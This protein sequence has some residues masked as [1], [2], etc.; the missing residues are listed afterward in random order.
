M[1]YRLPDD[2]TIDGYSAQTEALKQRSEEIAIQPLTQISVITDNQ[3]PSNSDLNIEKNTL[4]K[5]TES[6]SITENNN[7][8]LPVTS[9]AFLRRR[10]CIP[11][12]FYY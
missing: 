8:D 11:S 10:Y 7:S 5:Q 4:S 3:K 6:K 9:A 12:C 1:Q 2:S